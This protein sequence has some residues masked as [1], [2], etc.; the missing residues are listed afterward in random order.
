M[1]SRKAM[2]QISIRRKTGVNL[3]CN[4]VLPIRIA[5]YFFRISITKIDSIIKH[6]YACSKFEIHY[7]GHSERPEC[8]T[9]QVYFIPDSDERI[10]C[11]QPILRITI[12]PIRFICP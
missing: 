12:R 2:Y 7:I 10:D 11:L 1:G 8:L 6:I 3:S 5:I 4:S 9:G